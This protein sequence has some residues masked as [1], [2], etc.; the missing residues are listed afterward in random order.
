MA[1]RNFYLDFALMKIILQNWV[2]ENLV[3]ILGR[4]NMT[5]FQEVPNSITDIVTIQQ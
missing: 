3:F 5:F 2:W 4:A 1:V